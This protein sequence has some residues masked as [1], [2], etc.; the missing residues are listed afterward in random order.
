MELWSSSVLLLLEF[1]AFVPQG[2]FGDACGLHL[3]T[4]FAIANTRAI[5][6]TSAKFSGWA[7][8]QAL[9]ILVGCPQIL[10]AP[11]GGHGANVNVGTLMTRTVGSG[12]EWI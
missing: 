2:T 6:G 10:A 3:C 5:R 1:L 7:P 9:L 12:R 8:M 11:F 4:L